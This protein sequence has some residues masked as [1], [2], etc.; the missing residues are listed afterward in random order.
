MKI[1]DFKY[2]ELI[3]ALNSHLLIT[4]VSLRKNPTDKISLLD[5]FI[6]YARKITDGVSIID[7]GDQEQFLKQTV[8]PILEVYGLVIRTKEKNPKPNTNWDI[9]FYYISEN[10]RKFYQAI[11][12]Y[13]TYIGEKMEEW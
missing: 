13:R 8:C 1:G 2:I 10:G 7:D 9:N 6:L 5:C 4:P 3:N 12:V 11:Q